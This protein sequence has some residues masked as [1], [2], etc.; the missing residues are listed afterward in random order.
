MQVQENQQPGTGGSVSLPRSGDTAGC[1][2]RSTP[3]ASIPTASI[4]TASI[5]A[6]SILTRPIGAAKAIKLESALKGM[7][8]PV[9]PGAER[10]YK[11]KGLIK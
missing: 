11:E 9:H 10:F 6:A 5:P 3:A 2:R 8:V 7:P 1:V 4:P